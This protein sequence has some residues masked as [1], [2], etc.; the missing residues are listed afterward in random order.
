MGVAVEDPRPRSR[1]AATAPAL[2]M[3]AQIASLQVGSAVAK[4]AYASAGP[5]ALAGM[6][7]F[8]AALVLWLLVRP[9]LRGSRPRSG[10]R[11]SRSAWCSRP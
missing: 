9:R 5:T 1:G 4:G 6:R 2:M 11:P 8:F 3:L 10:G 7:L